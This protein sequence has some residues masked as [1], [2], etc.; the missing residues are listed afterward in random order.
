V[1][2]IYRWE[3]SVQLFN[4]PRKALADQIRMVAKER[5][6]TFIGSLSAQEMLEDERAIRVQLGLR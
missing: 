6:T 3:A 1:S 4:E 5:L 2:R